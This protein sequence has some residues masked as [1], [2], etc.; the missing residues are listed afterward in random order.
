MAVEVDSRK[1]ELIALSLL[2]AFGVGVA[3]ALDRNI[4]AAVFAVESVAAL[5]AAILR[6]R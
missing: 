6:S 2:S 4:I 5:V 3:L 1:L